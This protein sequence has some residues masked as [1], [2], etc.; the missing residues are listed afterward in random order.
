MEVLRI[1]TFPPHH[2]LHKNVLPYL[3]LFNWLSA[4]GCMP[5]LGVISDGA[6]TGC[7]LSRSLQL[8]A[9]QDFSGLNYWKGVI[10]SN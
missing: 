1:W 8:Q 4:S 9:V 6:S 7:V 5:S 2:P 3:L 10:H